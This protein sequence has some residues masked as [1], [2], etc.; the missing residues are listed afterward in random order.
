MIEKDKKYF[1]LIKSKNEDTVKL[2]E[3]IIDKLVNNIEFYKKNKYIRIVVDV[4]NYPN[5][6]VKK[7]WI[8]KV[9]E[10]YLG[11]YKI[12]IYYC[13]IN[14]YNCNITIKVK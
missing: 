4:R 8:Y 11:S 14:Y 5:C 6:G 9:C 7:D 10:Y 12:D 2:K 13:L 1:E 3:F